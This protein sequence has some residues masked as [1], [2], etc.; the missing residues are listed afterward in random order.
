MHPP[1]PYFTSARIYFGEIVICDCGEFGLFGVFL[2][3]LERDAGQLAIAIKR[4]KHVDR[5]ISTVASVYS[6]L[7]R[8]GPFNEPVVPV[9]RISV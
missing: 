8:T 4:K 3:F 6:T 9:S 7:P 1:I 2:E 5:R